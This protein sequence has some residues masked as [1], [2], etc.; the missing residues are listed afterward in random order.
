MMEHP[1]AYLDW[2]NHV[3][4]P[5]YDFRSSG[6]AYFNYRLDLGE[7]DLSANYPHGNPETAGLLAQR[8]RV[9]PENVFISSEGASGQ[10][11]RIIRLLAERSRKKKE[12]IVEYPTYEPLLRQAQ[13]H[14][15]KVK[16]LERRPEESYKLDPD[17]LR[18]T[19]SQKTG[20]LVLTNPHAPSGAVSTSN[21]LE[22][23]CE[24]ANELDFFIMCDEIYAEFNRNT[25]PSVFSAD[26]QHGIVTTSFTKAYGMGGLKLGTALTNKD[27]VKELYVDVSNTVGNS[28]NLV[29]IAATEL[30]TKGKENMEKHK[31]RWAKLKDETEKLLEHMGL[32]YFP[33][34][35]SVTYWV[36]LPIEDTYRWINEHTIPKHSLAPVP[37]AFFLFKN[38]YEPAESEM[39][40]LG[41]GNINPARPNLPEAFEALEESMNTWPAKQH[42]FKDTKE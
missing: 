21:E 24:V 39:I 10:N 9:Q 1:S 14:F 2:Y 3:E 8:Y 18:K 7:V 6:L 13:E 40:R 20:L 31:E 16:R 37:G 33:N 5:K 28:P 23:L 12:A 38:G 29:Q 35:V 17:E 42:Q 36:K 41:L 4:K 25:V 19:A 32:E 11:A 15:P 27:L 22:E 34:K 26:P 30:L